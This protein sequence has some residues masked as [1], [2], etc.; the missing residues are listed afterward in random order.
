MPGEDVYEAPSQMVQADV[1][2]SELPYSPTGQL[3]QSSAESWASAA[4]EEEV[5]ILPA[6]HEVQSDSE[7]DLYEPKGQGVQV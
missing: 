1:E 6:G 5:V 2:P 7:A 4:V 3:K